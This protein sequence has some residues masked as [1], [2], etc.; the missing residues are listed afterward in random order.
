MLCGIITRY[1]CGST[2]AFKPAHHSITTAISHRWWPASPG[3]RLFFAPFSASLFVPSQFQ[4]SSGHQR[5]LRWWTTEP[6]V[7]SYRAGNVL[8]ARAHLATFF[9]PPSPPPWPRGSTVFLMPTR[10]KCRPC[11]WIA[12]LALS[13]VRMNERSIYAPERIS[14]FIICS[15]S[16]S[17]IRYISRHAYYRRVWS[18]GLSL[19]IFAHFCL[20][21]ERFTCTWYIITY[22]RV[23]S[24]RWF[25]PANLPA[26]K[27]L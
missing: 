4:M 14:E 12:Q 24:E 23:V 27:R 21:S 25:H 22:V 18:H 13:D 20:S 6:V 1:N 11:V 9:S 16:I 7:R 19:T 2:H 10:K 8:S 17:L 15:Q 26:N 3:G 5:G